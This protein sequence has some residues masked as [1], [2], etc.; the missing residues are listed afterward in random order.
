MKESGAIRIEG[1]CP[2]G[3]GRLNETVEGYMSMNPRSLLSMGNEGPLKDKTAAS[4]AVRLGFL[5]ERFQ[6]G[7][8]GTSLEPDRLKGMGFEWF[9]DVS[10]ALSSFKKDTYRNWCRI[11]Y[12]GEMFPISL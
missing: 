7:V 6:L 5:K 10:S 4:V 11:E 1:R 2:E 3:F 8:A 12:G 9:P